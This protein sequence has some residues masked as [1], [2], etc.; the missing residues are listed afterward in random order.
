MYGM[1]NECNARYKE[2]ELREKDPNTSTKTCFEVRG[3]A[4][5]P[6]L[7]TEEFSLSTIGYSTK[8][9]PPRDYNLQNKKY[10]TPTLI[11][12]HKR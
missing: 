2:I 6:H 10:T 7:H 12:L 11:P 9:P 1:S 3:T 5:R 8:G 4:L